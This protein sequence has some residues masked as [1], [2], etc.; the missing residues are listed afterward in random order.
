VLTSSILF[1]QVLF[2]LAINNFLFIT[3]E[4]CG[5]HLTLASNTP[6][7]ESLLYYMCINTY[8]MSCAVFCSISS[9]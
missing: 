6:Q 2:L 5:L 4:H 3:K 7:N 9:V 1:L 8:S